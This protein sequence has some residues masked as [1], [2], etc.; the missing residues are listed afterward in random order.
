MCAGLVA[1][2]L[3]QPGVDRRVGRDQPVEVRTEREPFNAPVTAGRAEPSES[4]PQPA[5]GKA[6]EARLSDGGLVNRASRDFAQGM[7]SSRCSMSRK[8]V[9][10]ARMPRFVN[11]VRAQSTTPIARRPP[12]I[13]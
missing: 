7:S 8:P 2:H 3:R 11:H 12:A 4:L 1:L 10:L 9:A 5:L 6:R 13:W